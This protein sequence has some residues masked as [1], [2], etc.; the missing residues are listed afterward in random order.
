MVHFQTKGLLMKINNR[1]FIWIIIALAVIAGAGWALWSRYWY[2]LP[3][4]L[5]RFRDPIQPTMKVGWTSGRLPAQFTAANRPP[6]IVLI[7][8]DDLGFN[9]ITFWGGGVAGGR[10]ATPAIDSI[11]KDGVA[12]SRCY[13]GNATC[14]PSRA[15][16]MTGRYATRFGFEFTPAP[17]ELSKI[18]AKEMPAGQAIYHADLEAATPPYQAMVVP[19][20]EV[21]IGEMIRGRGYRTIHLGKWHLGET[22]ES[23]PEARGFDE[24]LSMYAGAGLYLPKD[25]PNVVNSVQ[26]FDPI[27]RFLWANLPFAITHNGSRRF[28]P[29]EYMTDYLSNE[30]VRVIAA[31][32]ERPFFL[33]LAYNAP[34]TPLQALKADYD[35]LAEIKD[36][37]LRV[38]AAMIKSLDRGIGRVLAALKAQGLNE[39]TIVMF[40][41]DNGGANY[42][43]LPDINKP[44]R[45]FKCTFFEGGIR[46]PFF[47]KWPGRIS[48]GSVF[49]NPVAHV[50]V[51]ATAAQASGAILPAD[52][53]IDGVDLMPYAAGK[54]TGFPHSSFFFRSGNYRVL[55]SG[56][57]KLKVDDTQKKIWL[58][59]MVRDPAEQKNL[60]AA[61]P[62][63]VAALQAELAAINGEQAKPL[64]PS[65]I[66]GRIDIDVP[67]GLPESGK[68]DYVYWAN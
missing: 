20:G 10:V 27:D 29:P 32:R 68:G 46:V 66:E 62:V 49:P 12:F 28:T 50:D 30:A 13:A 9:D 53:I 52:R 22:P 4:L 37:R 3:G 11:A 58:F 38:Y 40:T 39:N 23:R 15:A 5:A 60:A 51:F 36:H 8:A 2:Y 47:M 34:H 43:G 56:G 17:M 48:A 21:M 16:L 44:Y 25:A 14:A 35:A 57:W 65:L 33:Y 59:D 64:W 7:V 67:L 26:D 6:N 1:K 42:I 41:S 18:I 63:R 54:K 55:L 24:T 19:K 61:E 45:G 31:N